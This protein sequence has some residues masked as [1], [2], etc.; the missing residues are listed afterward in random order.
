MAVNFYQ[1]QHQPE[2]VKLI[3]YNIKLNCNK[4]NKYFPLEN[5]KLHILNKVI[6]EL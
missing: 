5:K 4:F 3:L 1:E 2:K 6:T